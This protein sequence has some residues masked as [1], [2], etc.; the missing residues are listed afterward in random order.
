MKCYQKVNNISKYTD[1]EVLNEIDDENTVKAKIELVL[2][3][4]DY[5][6]KINKDFENLQSLSKILD[7]KNLNGKNSLNFK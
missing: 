2:A 5:I 4:E 1:F 7:N 3:E 6:R